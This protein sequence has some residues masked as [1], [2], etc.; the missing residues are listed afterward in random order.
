MRA[1]KS[2]IAAARPLDPQDCL[3]QARL[4]EMNHADP[5]KPVR[6]I[7]IARAKP[8]GLLLRR[9]NLLQLPRVELAQPETR[10][11]QYRVAVEL[12]CGFEFGN[13]GLVVVL[14]PQHLSLPEMRQRSATR[15]M[16]HFLD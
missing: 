5:P 14:R 4:Q 7:R 10:Q 9:N 12:D 2:R 15:R 3:I 13:S 8:D 1:G 11:R 6:N 16:A